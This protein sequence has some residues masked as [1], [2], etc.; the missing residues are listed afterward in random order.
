MR[1][2]IFLVLVALGLI[3]ILLFIYNPDLLEKIWL[4]LVGLIG[5]IISSIKSLI[6]GV[7]NFF[8]ENEKDDV[9]KENKTA[10]KEQLNPKQPEANIASPQPDQRQLAAKDKEISLLKL[11]VK[12]LEYA[13][14]SSNTELDNFQGTTLTVLRYFDDQSTTLGLLFIENEFFCYTLEDTYRP[15]KIM[16]ETRI[17]SGTYQLGFNEIESNTTS[18]YRKGRPWFKYHLHVKDVPNYSGILIH[19]GNTKEDTAGC[20]LVADSI[21]GGNKLKTVYDSWKA[22]ERLYKTLRPKIENKEDVRI[23]YYDEDWFEK[24]N[25]KRIVA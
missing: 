22:F 25:L 12:E 1:R 6:N 16:K 11:K 13:L 8:K 23:R 2:A 5:V 4:W 19:V 7:L 10:E 24:F 17:P 21:S 20:L 3:A 18:R 9:N 15:H 14:S